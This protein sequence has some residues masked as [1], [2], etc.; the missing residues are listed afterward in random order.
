MQTICKRIIKDA[1]HLIHNNR[2]PGTQK[3]GKSILTMGVFV[4]PH[5]G[6]VIYLLVVGILLVCL[7]VSFI[8]ATMLKWEFLYKRVRI[9]RYKASAR[10]QQQQ[11]QQQKQQRQLQQQQQKQ[12]QESEKKQLKQ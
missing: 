1:D 10:K 8:I 9:E 4:Q 11:Q 5:G 7:V 3:R 2:R 6:V 12:E